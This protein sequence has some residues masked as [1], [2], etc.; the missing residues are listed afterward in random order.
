MD[1]SRF[2]DSIYALPM[3]I[4]YPN[5]THG[6]PNVSPGLVFGGLIFRRIFELACRGPIFWG[7]IFGILKYFHYAFVNFYE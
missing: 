1:L 5:Y 7:L 6:I 3:F 2:R 4:H